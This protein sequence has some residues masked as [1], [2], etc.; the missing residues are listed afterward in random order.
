MTISVERLGGFLFR[1]RSYLPFL[2]TPVFALA[3]MRFH[4][5]FRSPVTDVVWEVACVLLSLAGLALRVYTVG[6]A[7]RG[8]SGRNTRA[9]KAASLNT[10]GPYSVMRHPLYVANGVIVLG[11][12]LFPHSWLVPPVVI[13]V[14]VAY[15]RCIARTE[16]AYLRSRFGRAFE[17]WA[18]SLIHI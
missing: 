16:E 9:Q 17:A 4:V 18:L 14:T 15:Y 10:T 8:T 2:L 7:A 6:V 11:F 13:L 3:M 5:L 12:S 1:W